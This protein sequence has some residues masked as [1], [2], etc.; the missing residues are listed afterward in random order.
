MRCT[1]FATFTL[2]LFAL[3]AN[4]EPHIFNSADECVAQIERLTPRS[5]SP[6]NFEALHLDSN[7]NS[8]SNSDADADADADAEPSLNWTSGADAAITTQSGPSTPPNSP[9][10]KTVDRALSVLVWNTYKFQIPGAIDLISENKSDLI[11]LQE[12][13]SNSHESLASRLNMYAQFG[14]GYL[15]S[16]G[17][18]GVATLSKF[19][20]LTVC[21]WQHEE[22][23]LKSPKATL[24]TLYRIEGHH[25]LTINVHSIN[26]TLSTEAWQAQLASVS[27][28][29]KS[30]EGRLILAGDFNTWS[31]ERLALL[32]QLRLEHVLS[33]VVPTPDQRTRVFGNTLDHLLVRGLKVDKSST[34]VTESSDHNAVMATL[35]MSDSNSL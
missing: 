14:P 7:S 6:S 18:T 30:Y 31:N 23:W 11:L 34:L 3:S 29:L 15:G 35:I 26:F 27:Q 21:S 1:D 10:I 16:V 32:E 25:L 5:R 17:Q 33:T 12:S 22:P 13:V 2:I 19:A 20:P 4:A 9:S 28:L 8:N 24:V